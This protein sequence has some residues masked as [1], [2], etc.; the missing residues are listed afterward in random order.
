LSADRIILEGLAF[1]GYHGVKAEEKSLGQRFLVDLALEF[2]LGPA[3]RSDDLA[4][5]IDYGE[6]Y[7]LARE[8]VEGTS[9]DTL[10]AVA[11]ALAAGLLDRF[12][13]L[14]AVTVR[15]KKPCAPI[16]GAHFGMVAVEIVR[17]RQDQGRA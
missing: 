8:T 13:R 1:Y 9:R 4:L 2:D 6:A 15:V 14:E 17:R 3:G 12:G 16:T 7:R 11:E 10:E 5:T